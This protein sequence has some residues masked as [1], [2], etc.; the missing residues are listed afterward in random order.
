MKKALIFLL[1]LS[2]GLL[3]AQDWDWLRN[4]NSFRI[5]GYRFL[6][7]DS[8]GN[9]Y[10]AGWEEAGVFLSEDMVVSGYGGE[11]APFISKYTASGTVDW[12]FSINA[13]APST[14]FLSYGIPLIHTDREDRLWFSGSYYNFCE[15]GQSSLEPV[16]Q[17]HAYIAAVGPEGDLLWHE[18]LAYSDEAMQ[19]TGLELDSY[20]HAYVSG[21]FQGNLTI[22]EEV[23]Y[24]ERKTAFIAKL[25]EN[26]ALDWLH[27]LPVS[28][29]GDNLGGGLLVDQNRDVYLNGVFTGTC[30]FGGDL[31][32]TALNEEGGKYIVKINQ[33]RTFLWG[34]TLEAGTSSREAKPMRDTYNNVYICGGLSSSMNFEGNLYDPD[35]DGGVFILKMTTEGETVWLKQYG[36][37]GNDRAHYSKLEVGWYNR[38]YLSAKF[39]RE[40]NIGGFEFEQDESIFT[41]NYL[42]VSELNTSGEVL[43]AKH[44]ASYESEVVGDS[45]DDAYIN[46]L[47]VDP[48]GDLYVGGFYSGHISMNGEDYL[49]EDDISGSVIVGDL[50]IGKLSTGELA[51]EEWDAVAS[52]QLLGNPVKENLQLKSQ[53]AGQIRLFGLNGQL[54]L[55]QNVDQGLTEISLLAYPS[56]VYLL[57]I[58]NQQGVWEQHKLVLL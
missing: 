43:R 56:G 23:V 38:L 58:Q 7:H 46:A 16:S 31:S 39:E 27:V 3:L 20:D 19:I 40:T 24:R 15:I 42:Y 50:F 36:G 54:L 2:S 28:V 14:V 45:Q 21:W 18:L 13:D 29:E 57:A 1:F 11:F 26:R 32:G 25:D 10:G 55:E 37:V 44:M 52:Y 22:G 9:V 17:Q 47:S 41:S 8:E 35:Q 53:Q 12:A 49:C 51:L 30:N 4:G 48:S 6:E 33:N 5:D 34:K